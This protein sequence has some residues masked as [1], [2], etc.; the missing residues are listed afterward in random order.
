M[1]VPS[2][3][4]DQKLS[5]RVFERTGE[6]GPGETH[7][8]RQPWSSYLNRIASQVSFAADESVTGAGP[9]RPRAQRPRLDE[10]CRS[11]RA[12]AHLADMRPD[13]TTWPK[14]H[15]HGRALRA[16]FSQYARQLRRA[17]NGDV[18]LHD[19]E[20]VD[21]V[22][23]RAGGITVL[24]RQGG[25]YRADH[26]LLLT[27][28]AGAPSTSPRVHES[29]GT[30]FVARPYPLHEA[31]PPD[32]VPRAAVVGCAGMGLAAIDVI[33]HLTE[34]RGGRFLDDGLSGALRYCASHHEPRSIVA[35]SESGLFTFARPENAK[36]ADRS[37]E[38][39]GVFFT[40]KALEL[41][42]R[43]MVPSSGAGTPQLDFDADVLP[44]LVL[45]MAYVHYR[46]LY[47]DAVGAAVRSAA[48]T[49]VERHLRGDGRAT[50]GAAPPEGLLPAV[51]EVVEQV[52]HDLDALLGTGVADVRHELW[53]PEQVLRHWL[54]VVLEPHQAEDVL[55]QRSTRSGEEVALPDTVRELSTS[56]WGN[57]F[58][59]ED[60]LSP[61]RQ[62]PYET[63]EQYRDALLE[64]MRRDHV[65]AR[66]GSLQNPLKASC[67]AVWRDLRPVITH[68]VDDAGLT[69]ASHERFLA[70]YSRLHNRLANGAAVEVMAKMTALIEHGLLDVGA[71]PDARAEPQQGPTA[72]VV[73]V[74]PRTGARLP[75]DVLVRARVERFDLDG[76]CP[77]LY[78]RMA[79]R[80][81]L[82]KWRNTGAD[83]SC[84]EPGGL[85][86]T[87]DHRVRRA[88]GTVLERVSVLGPAAEGQRTFLLSALRPDC[89]HYVMQ[90]ILAWLRGL[91]PELVFAS[92]PSIPGAREAAAAKPSRGGPTGVVLPDRARGPAEWV[93]AGAT[94]GVNGVP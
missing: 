83:G 21:V 50:G 12:A 29:G 14:R 44:L 90:D 69:P 67:D 87:A 91:A 81:S 26:V 11:D 62:Q 39:R 2:L 16:S 25:S 1:L 7:S 15:V 30:T 47:G 19:E 89:D 52:G 80:G 5:V 55:R 71:G 40:R 18:R 45:E 8:S 3:R 70:R 93:A 94:H 72:R 84:Y 38:H 56:V 10:W 31:V 68:A 77:E 75:V 17:T 54:H 74:G 24:T 48:S 34:G 60:L 64:Y 46:T 28:H 33:L 66:Q 86:L 85:D 63:P 9:L 79:G 73:V 35:Y 32:L 49:A 53:D 51:T 76:N 42:R 65:W 59:W 23:D 41:R 43:A 4:K 57:R 82:R 22:E 92:L 27:G 6:F 20:V 36:S 13:P 37:L 88:D 58:S 61:L 78:R